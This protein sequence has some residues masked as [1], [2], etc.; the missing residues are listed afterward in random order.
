[1]AELGGFN[2]M[3]LSI[4]IVSYNTAQLTL[5]TIESVWTEVEGSSLLAGKTEIII[6]DNN[7]KDDSVSKIRRFLKRIPAKRIKSKIIQNP[8]NQGFSAA[9][10]LGIDHTSGDYILLLN[11]DTLLQAK[12]L[13]KM[14]NVF[15]HHPIQDSTATIISQS[16]KLDRLGILSAQLLNKD[17]S[18]Q[19]Q[20]GNLPSLFSLTCHMLMLDDLPVIG[21]FLPSTQHTGLRSD[22]IDVTGDSHLR[23]V[24]QQEWVGGTTMMIRRQV[25]DEIGKLDQAIFM[26]GEDIEFCWRALHHQWDIGIC[27]TAKV[28]HFGSA[29]SSSANAIKGEFKGYLYIWSKHQPLWQIFWVRMILK[30]GAYLRKFIFGTIMKQTERAKVYTTILSE[31]F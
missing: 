23:S 31:L 26:Y 17:L 15:L 10:N 20:G 22:T 27:P 18:L 28:I 30:S 14:V 12:A 25:I 4:I 2:S 5:Q 1:M 8:N 29:S 21:K 9:N 11:S 13:T 7:S 6:I 16:G 24:I 3:L 19:P